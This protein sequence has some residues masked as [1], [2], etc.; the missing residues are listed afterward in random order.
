MARLRI[1]SL[2]VTGQQPA[3]LQHPR[4]V[5]SHISGTHPDAPERNHCFDSLRFCKSQELNKSVEPRLSSLSTWTGDS[6]TKPV[7]RA[8]SLPR[9]SS[10]G[11]PPVPWFYFRSAGQNLLYT[12]ILLSPRSHKPSL[13]QD[14]AVFVKSTLKKSQKFW[15]IWEQKY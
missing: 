3:L 9:D 5:G 13:S 12:P 15:T 14:R 11:H 6:G 8:F 10:A 4:G 2:N 1:A 7:L